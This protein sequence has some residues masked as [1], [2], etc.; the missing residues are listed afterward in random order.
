MKRCGIVQHN[1]NCSPENPQVERWF[2]AFNVF[3]IGFNPILQMVEIMHWSTKTPH[4]RKSCHAR[5]DAMP[6]GIVIDEVCNWRSIYT[7][8][9]RMWPWA[10]ERHLSPQNIEQLGNLIETTLSQNTADFGDSLVA[11]T[12]LACCAKVT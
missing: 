8:F 6:T 12:S 1:H 2:P 9:K 3:Y 10:D 7:H 11:R 4:L 5:L